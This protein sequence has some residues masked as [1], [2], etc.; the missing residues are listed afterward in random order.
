VIARVARGV[1]AAALLLGLAGLARADT[2]TTR[3][4]VVQIQV[5]CAEGEVVCDDVTYRGKSRRSGK[6]L[7]L[8]GK[9]LHSLCADGV[10]PCRFLG[11][12]FRNGAFLYRV[13]DSGKLRVTRGDKVVVEESGAWRR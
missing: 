2:L 6:S 3:S 1:F 10:T 11:Y 8:K 13:F 4:F 12:E 7:E 9:T 5:N